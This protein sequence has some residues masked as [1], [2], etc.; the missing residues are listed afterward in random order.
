MKNGWSIMVN[1]F[2][3]II[4]EKKNEFRRAISRRY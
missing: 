2:Y 1:N 3:V 4:V